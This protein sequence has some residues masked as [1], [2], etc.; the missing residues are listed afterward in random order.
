MA[1]TDPVE[2]AWKIHASL[3]DWTG[4]VDAKAAFALTLESAAI[5]ALTAFFGTGNQPERLTGVF[6]KTVFWLGIALL[7][8]SALAA[9]SVVSPRLRS[10]GGGDDWREHFVYFGH[11][12]HWEPAR[13]AEKLSATPPLETLSRQLVVMSEIAW[14]KHRRVQQSLQFAVAGVAAVGLAWIVG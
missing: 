5:G 3:Q 14:K 12:R 13:L 10:K 9:V 1:E 6:P 8:L 11:L 4:K 7:A 2:T